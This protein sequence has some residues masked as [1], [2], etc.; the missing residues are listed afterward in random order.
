MIAINPDN[1]HL[2]YRGFDME[3][4]P[5]TR[6]SEFQ[7]SSL[8]GASRRNGYR[9]QYMEATYHLPEYFE[10]PIKV[11]CAIEFAQN[12]HSSTVFWLTWPDDGT[13]KMRAYLYQ[14]QQKRIDQQEKWLRDHVGA[15]SGEYSWGLIWNRYN[16]HADYF[17]IMVMFR[18]DKLGDACQPG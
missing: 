10:D 14:N 6:L 1:G 13:A 9:P 7:N 4:T 5:H 2:R 12:I 3:V 8:A 15:P 11:Q 16:I 17:D 18:R